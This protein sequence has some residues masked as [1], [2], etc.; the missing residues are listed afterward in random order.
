MQNYG[1][2]NDGATLDIYLSREDLAALSNMT[3]S[4]AIRTLSLFAS[5]RIIALDGRII[6]II[7]PD[8]LEKI[9]KHG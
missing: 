7:D 5:E 9:S 6:K 4:N 1:L 3:T 2:E 8:G